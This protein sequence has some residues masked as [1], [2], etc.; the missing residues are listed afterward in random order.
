MNLEPEGA[1]QA[2]PRARL[3]GR[4]HIYVKGSKTASR[5]AVMAPGLIGGSPGPAQPQVASGHGAGL[6]GTACVRARTIGNPYSRT[7]GT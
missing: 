5:Q 2:L 4:S 3:Y 1:L 7:Y 6:G